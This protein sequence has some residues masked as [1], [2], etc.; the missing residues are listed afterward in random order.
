MVD[1]ISVIGFKTCGIVRVRRAR[2]LRLSLLVLLYSLSLL[3]LLYSVSLLV[4]LY[5]LYR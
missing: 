5:R 2:V 1:T 4:L 3:V